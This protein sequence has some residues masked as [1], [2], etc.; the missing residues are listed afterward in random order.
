MK[1]Q[2][3]QWWA[4]AVAACLAVVCLTAAIALS[5]G[6]ALVWIAES[7]GGTREILRN[8]MAENYGAR[9]L[10]D[11]VKSDFD[12]NTL[13][14]LD[15][16]NLN[17]TVVQLA[18][19]S[20][21]NL[22]GDNKVLYSNCGETVNAKNYSYYME[23]GD[24]YFDYDTSSAFGMIVHDA[25]SMYDEAELGEF[26]PVAL[27]NF[28]LDMQNGKLYAKTSE[29]YYLVRELSVVREYSVKDY[30]TEDDLINA[31]IISSAYTC[32]KLEMLDSDTDTEATWR[33]TWTYSWDDE[34]LLYRNVFSADGEEEYLNFEECRKWTIEVAGGRISPEMPGY[35]KLVYVTGKDIPEDMVVT[36]YSV[37]I[38]YPYV[39]EPVQW[40]VKDPYAVYMALKNPVTYDIIQTKGGI[41]DY[42]GEVEKWCYALNRLNDWGGVYAAIAWLLSLLFLVVFTCQLGHRADA[43]GIVTRKWDR[44]PFGI[45]VILI[46]CGVFLGACGNAL[47]LEMTEWLPLMAF[48]VL[49]LLCCSVWLSFVLALYA[50]VVVR[51]KSGTFWHTTLLYCILK[52]IRRLFGR[53]RR[54]V[55]EQLSLMWKVSLVLLG[56]TL[57]QFIVIGE[58]GYQPDMEI[59][60]FF[61]YKLV[62]IPGV[63]VVCLQ[64]NRLKKGGERIA[65]GNYQEPID[66]KGMFWEFKKHAEN[67]NHVGDGISLAVEEQM[68]SERFRTELITNVS[69]DIKTPLTSIINYVDLMKK[70]NITDPTVQEYMEVLDR[71]SLRLKKLIEDLMEASKA[72]TG[73]L[74]VNAEV[75]DATVMLSQVVGE[76]EERAKENGLELIVESPKPPVEILADGRHLWRIIDNLMVNACKYAMPGTRVYIDLERFN[77]M[78]IMT[79]RNISKN[80]LNVSS[81]ELMERFVRGDSSRNTEGSGLGLSIAQSLALLMDGN[82]AIQVDGDL[83]KAIVSFPEYHK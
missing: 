16:G 66:T 57:L 67:I 33:I 17:Y 37:Y 35:G 80:R 71:Q 15:G 19:D 36:T 14:E 26:T 7:E 82:M 56:I 40:E 4:K 11:A 44:I 53:F 70:E 74:P 18:T 43:E 62:E 25:N 9:L 83:F 42:F 78:V 68:K 31:G 50:T 24:G 8:R 30:P 1:K 69:H 3:Y 63:I 47:I 29:H 60:L 73:N 2:I 48:L 64:L 79:F 13:Q 5:V 59:V 58:T 76:F 65:E 20:E 49:E 28:C 39:Y 10:N 52:P 38:E 23:G 22:T 46:I 81:E 72:S 61:L 77:G 34:A 54:L 32:E 41:A 12:K 6:T 55:R 21:G 51:L 45:L 27:Q 75:C